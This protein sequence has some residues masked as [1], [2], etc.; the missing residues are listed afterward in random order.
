MWRLLRCFPTPPNPREIRSSTAKSGA[1]RRLRK[2]EICCQRTARLM[3]RADRPCVSPSKV[4]AQEAKNRRTH[5]NF[6]RPRIHLNRRRRAT[7]LR[8]LPTLRIAPRRKLLSNLLSNPCRARKSLL[9]HGPIVG[10]GLGVPVLP[11]KGEST[12]TPPIGKRRSEGVLGKHK[13]TL[14]A[15]LLAGLLNRLSLV[16]LRGLFVFESVPDWFK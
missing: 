11:L 14:Q 15:H 12:S 5:E 8:R 9:E 6:L 13:H 16:V 10:A 4:A 3:R 7:G 1:E 2:A